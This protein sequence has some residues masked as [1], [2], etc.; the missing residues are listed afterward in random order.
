M[1]LVAGLNNALS[2]M[3]VAQSQISVVSNNIANIDTEGYTRKTA[4][5]QSAVLAGFG[6]GVTLKN[7][8][9]TVDQSLLR[10]YLIWKLRKFATPLI[11]S[12]I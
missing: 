11:Q 10:S 9:R 4:A 5:Q 2:G 1:A 12:L 8:Q 3:H 6:A 7:A